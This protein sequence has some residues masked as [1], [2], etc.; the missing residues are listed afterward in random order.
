MAALVVIGNGQGLGGYA[1]GKAP[2]HRTTYAVASAM[3][4]ASRKLFFVELLEGRTIFQD[5]YAEC[6]NTR[7]F[8]QRGPPGAGLR[9]HPRLEKI[10]EVLFS[11]NFL[12][13]FTGNLFSLLLLVLFAY[14]VG[15]FFCFTEFLLCYFLFSKCLFCF[16]VSPHSGACSA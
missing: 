11:R 12:Y 4:M 3:K 2:I 14:D 13:F 16:V 5:F 7:I 15:Y 10:C 1:V 9:C 8:A 6:R